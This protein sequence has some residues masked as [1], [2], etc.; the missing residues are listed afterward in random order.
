MNWSDGMKKT[1]EILYC[2]QYDVT[3]DKVF[4]QEYTPRETKYYYEVIFDEAIEGYA[5]IDKEK[6]AKEY[7]RENTIGGEKIFYVYTFNGDVNHAM[8][9]FEKELAKAIAEEEEKLGNVKRV[10]DTLLKKQAEMLSKYPNGVK[11]DGTHEERY[12]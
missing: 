11:E 8:E 1:D 7:V 9:L 12:N 4:K 3:N 6:V 10:H 5:C 2:F